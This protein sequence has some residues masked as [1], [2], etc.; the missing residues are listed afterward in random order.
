M[1]ARLAEIALWLHPIEVGSGDG[2]AI[3]EKD[4]SA[5]ENASVVRKLTWFIES[6]FLVVVG[7]SSADLID[8]MPLQECELY[9]EILVGPTLREPVTT[10]YQWRSLIIGMSRKL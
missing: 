1:I 9:F 4:D 10:A 3:A 2:F 5:I 8:R 6:Y 7:V